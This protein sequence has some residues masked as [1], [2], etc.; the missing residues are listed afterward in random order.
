MEIGKWL[1]Q[2]GAKDSLWASFSPCLLISRHLLF[3]K[4]NLK[5][6]IEA[7]ERSI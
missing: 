2:Y 5:V 7:W 3:T 1:H 4:T 6:K